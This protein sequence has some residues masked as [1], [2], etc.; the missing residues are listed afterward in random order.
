MPLLSRM[1]WL[2]GPLGLPYVPI[3]P[4]LPLLGP[5]GLLPY[6]TK[7]YIEFGEPIEVGQMGKEAVND[8]VLVNRLNEK[9]RQQIQT[10]VDRRLAKRRSVFGG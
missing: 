9:V 10:M 3:T 7:W 1:S 6:P 4:T 2:A 5:L 8:R